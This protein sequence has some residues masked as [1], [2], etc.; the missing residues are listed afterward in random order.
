MIL[1]AF[2]LGFIVGAIAGVAAVYWADKP[3]KRRGR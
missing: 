1:L 3:E 2:L